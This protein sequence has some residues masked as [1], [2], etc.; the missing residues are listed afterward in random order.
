MTART[1]ANIEWSPSAF[2]G[3]TELRD[4]STETLVGHIVEERGQF[5]I[6]PEPDSI[7]DGINEGPYPTHQEACFTVGYHVGGTCS[8]TARDTL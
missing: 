2:P 6:K 4:S 3:K 1:I 8:P 7:L 5:L